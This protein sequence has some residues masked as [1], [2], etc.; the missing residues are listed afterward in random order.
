MT[1]RQRIIVWVWIVAIVALGI[2]PP[3]EFRNGPPSRY[4][5]LF[6]PPIGVGRIEV[7]TSRLVIEWLI[8]TAIA[9]A[10]YFTLR[11]PTKAPVFI[12]G[13]PPP[14]RTSPLGNVSPEM[15]KTYLEDSIAGVLTEHEEEG[16]AIVKTFPPWNGFLD[17]EDVL[18]A[19]QSL[20]PAVLVKRIVDA[21]PGT[22]FGDLSDMPPLEP[23]KAVLRML[24]GFDHFKRDE[25]SGTH[26]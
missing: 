9:G 8:T 20:Q 23:L 10:A 11:T 3:W 6:A 2:Y 1:L 21:N 18:V 22:H 12:R 19:V 24:N 16:E 25:D 7:D 15:F 26:K 17:V 13:I 5:L 4:Y 14:T